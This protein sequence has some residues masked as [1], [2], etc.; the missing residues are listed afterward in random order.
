MMAHVNRVLPWWY[1]GMLG[2]CLINFRLYCLYRR[3]FA[4]KS[5]VV[6][7]EEEVTAKEKMSR[8]VRAK[9]QEVIRDDTVHVGYSALKRT[10]RS[11]G[12]RT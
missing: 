7:V 8:P 6:V 11:I 10:N 9:W 2:V 1:R 12:F 5:V 3:Q 4:V